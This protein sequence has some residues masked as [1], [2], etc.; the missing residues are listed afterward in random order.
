MLRHGWFWEKHWR[1]A[2]DLANGLRV[3][4]GT[5]ASAYYQD[6]EPAASP[7]GVRPRIHDARH[8]AASWWLSAGV[9]IHVVKAMLGHKSITTTIDTYGHL[10]PGAHDQARAGMATMS[11]LLS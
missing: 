10:L 2:V 1:P 11:G 9:D 8:T 3:K 5:R 7:I 6:V 4:P